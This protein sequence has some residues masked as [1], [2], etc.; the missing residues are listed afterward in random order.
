MI[1]DTSFDSAWREFVS[2]NPFLGLADTASAAEGFR[3]RHGKPLEAAGVLYRSVSG[4]WCV[5]P[6]FGAV[7][8]YVATRGRHGTSPETLAAGRNLAQA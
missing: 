5:T 7:V 6:D 2:A 3:R 8:L 4:R 1:P